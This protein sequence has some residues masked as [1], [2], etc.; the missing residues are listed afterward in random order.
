M[1]LHKGQCT[2]KDAAEFPSEG[3]ATRVDY[4][5]NGA[6]KRYLERTANTSLRIVGTARPFRHAIP[7]VEDSRAIYS[8]EIPSLFI[9]LTREPISFSPTP[10][11]HFRI[12]PRDLLDMISIHHFCSEMMEPR[13]RQNEME[14]LKREKM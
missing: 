12:P 10:E 6:H 4:L 2:S 14:K 5:H 3:C 9:A 7:A 11:N 13:N 8:P 1:W